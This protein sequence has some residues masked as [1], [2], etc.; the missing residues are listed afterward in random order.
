MLLNFMVCI[1]FVLVCNSLVG[2]WYDLRNGLLIDWLIGEGLGL[3]VSITNDW[4]LM[5]CYIKTCIREREREREGEELDISTCID[6]GISA[7]AQNTH[8]HTH[9]HMCT[10]THTHTLTHTHK[11]IST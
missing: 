9:T 6:V 5:D 10:H 7:Y 11:S 2:A 4:Y 8:T 3:V 1:L